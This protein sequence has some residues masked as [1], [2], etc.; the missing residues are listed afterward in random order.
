MLEMNVKTL[1]S[2]AALMLAAI[3]G[4]GDAL[5][6]YP[7]G[8]YN[9]LE[10]KC[11]AQ[12]VDAIR[13]MLADHVEISYSSGTWNAFLDT[14][15]KTVNGTDYWWDMYSNEL[16]AVSSGH[17]GMNVEHSV[18]N[19]WW[20][21]TKNAAY[22]DLVHLNPSNSDAN[23]RKSNYP[24]AELSEVKWTNGV[25]S[26][27]SPKSGQ[28]G[29]NSWG[30]EPA[31]QY[32]G[33]FARV[34]MYMFTVYGDISWK[35]TTAWM[36]NIGT[37]QM[38]KEWAR[39]MLMRWHAADPVSDKERSR[40]DGIY[41]NQKNRNPFIDLPDLADHIWGDKKN[42]A[43]YIDGS[44]QQEDPQPPTPPADDENLSYTWLS[45][46]DATLSDGWTYDN[47]TLPAA[48]SYIW[49][50]KSYNNSYYLNA[51]A[52]INSTAYQADAYAWSPEVSLEGCYSA[53]LKFEH[54]AK[55]QT[56]LRS[57]CS[58][59][60]RDV[61]T[62][63][64]T[65]VDIPN[66]PASGSW[67][68]VDSGEINLNQ[69]CGKKVNVGL[70]YRSDT[71]GADTWEIRNMT[72]AANR[73]TGYE[74][75][76]S[77]DGEDDSFLVEVWGNNI[78]APADALIFDINGRCVNGENLSRGIYIVYKPSFEKAVKVMVK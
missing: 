11:G 33:D 9:S 66:W 72:F 58:V 74:S 14:D 4:G 17:P 67:T 62:G 5:A 76:I 8:Y 26:V 1:I 71:T 13:D 61:A 69:F 35:T 55:F 22:K 25:T 64:I 45:A 70:H 65:D 6:S 37:S 75:T 15:V 57:L 43:F 46:S 73:T 78:F 27:G 7:A 50:W 32:K 31:D 39:E 53:T 34:F 23:S 52:Y 24:L 40:N 77:L 42:V 30:Y 19:S 63:T 38:F 20:G 36:Y 12:L 49:N 48:A 16:V 3:Y 56:T 2:S 29:G 28:G 68:F 18:A 21:G 10:G 41:K 51:S 44:G 60:V 47:V 59:A 54:A